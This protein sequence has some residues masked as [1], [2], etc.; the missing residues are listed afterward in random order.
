MRGTVD[1]DIVFVVIVLDTAG[2]EFT[3]AI[4]TFG[5]C[6]TVVLRRGDLR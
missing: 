3:V 6:S 1:F 4:E 2:F 5:H